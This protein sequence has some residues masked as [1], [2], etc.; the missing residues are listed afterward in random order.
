M[1]QQIRLPAA[2]TLMVAAAPLVTARVLEVPQKYPTIQQALDICAD[3]D[4]IL[5][6]PG[7]YSE[8]PDLTGKA[9]VLASRF[10]TTGDPMDIATTV[11]DGQSEGSVI[12]IGDATGGETR[13][14]GLTIAHGNAIDGG[15]V[16]CDGDATVFLENLIVEESMASHYGGGIYVAGAEADVSHC[17]VRGNTGGPRGGG[18]HYGTDSTV[19]M[20]NCVI[21]GN[22]AIAPPSYGHGAG[23]SC[24]D[25]V[26]AFI[27]HC[28]VDGNAAYVAAGGLWTN[29]PTRIENS[30][31]TRNTAEKNNGGGMVLYDPAEIVHCTITGNRLLGP[32][33]GGGI[34]CSRV[35]P[36]VRNSIIWGNEAGNGDDIFGPCTVEYSTIGGGWDGPGNLAGDPAL[37]TWHGYEYLLAPGSPAIDAGD[38]T[39]TD[40]IYDRHPRV[41]AIYRNG[42]RA[43][44][45]AYGGEYNHHW[46]R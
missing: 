6:S 34:F 37:T 5:V 35:T 20:R 21:E 33:N 26:S 11:I 22:E 15:G 2:L 8:R 23:V 32:L 45:G 43:D 38:P 41:P 10:L 36:V 19:R 18:V 1:T 9:I 17:L 31:F 13:I 42:S 29:T 16:Y 30:I 7:T 39:G 12:T 44:M 4:T 3:S 40:R 25:G 27:S 46:L 28:V 14:V 24:K